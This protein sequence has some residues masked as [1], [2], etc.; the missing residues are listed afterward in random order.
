MKKIIGIVSPQEIIVI[1]CN[2]ILEETSDNDSMF[3]NIDKFS[4][5]KINM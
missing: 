1:L 5:Y 2:I 4:R 3:S